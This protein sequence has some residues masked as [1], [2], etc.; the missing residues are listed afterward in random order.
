MK[1]ALLGN[2][3]TGKTSVFNL[4]TG[5]RQHTGNFPGVTVEKKIGTVKID[6][7]QATLIDFPGTYSLYPRSEDERI[8]SDILLNPAHEYYPDVCVVVLDASN[9]R[10]NLFLFS[11]LYDLG[12]PTVML[13]NMIDV[14]DRQGI[15]ISIE[16]LKKQFPTASITTCNARIKLGKER[17]IQAIKNVSKDEKPIPFYTP[18]SL[19]TLSDK[20]LQENEAQQRFERID[21]LIP[22]IVS[23]RKTEQRQ[24]SVQPITWS[25]RLDKILTHRIGG[26]L[27]FGA[28]LLLI[29][30]FIFSFATVPMDFIEEQ[31]GNLAD[32]TASILPEGIFNDLVS[33]GILSGI[34]GVVVFIPQIAIL[35]FFLAILEET[36]YMARVVFIMDKLMRP[37]GLNG[38]SVVPMISGVACAIPAVMAARTIA[39][40][41][42]RMITH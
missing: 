10:R 37:F 9:L 25:T 4:L 7:K 18:A 21:A 30:Q 36:G 3:N 6:H 27:I 38:K 8:V 15:D 29:F 32:W 28:V 40:W 42:E 41:K 33:K 13:L 17:I 2:P 14:A 20:Q 31:F 5:L 19:K 12:I 16:K 22:H 39:N 34:G 24:Q 1:I 23:Q 11:Q 26:Y 35:F